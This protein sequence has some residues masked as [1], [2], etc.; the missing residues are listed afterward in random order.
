MDP[1][2]LLAAAVLAAPAVLVLATLSV[3]GAFVA[4]LA[5]GSVAA[6]IVRRAS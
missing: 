4:S 5:D 2:L 6:G 3:V 1:V